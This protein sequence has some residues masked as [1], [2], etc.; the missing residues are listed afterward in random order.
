MTDTHADPVTRPS[1]DQPAGEGRG[2]RKAREKRST[3]DHSRPAVLRA[4]AWRDMLRYLRPHRGAILV[5]GGLTLLGGLSGLVQP[6]MAKSVV[7]GLQNESS[8]T[9]TLLLLSAFVLISAALGALGTFLLMRVSETVVLN[10]RREVIRKVL[11]LRVSETDK[12]PPGD[13]MSRATADTTLMRSAVTT[14]I[15]ETVNG[16]VMLTTIVVLMGFMDVV[17][18]LTTLGVLLLGGVVIGVGLPQLENASRRVQEGV[19]ELSTALERVLGTFRTIKAS[20]A[21]HREAEIAERGARRAWQSSLKVARLESFIGAFITVMIQISFLAVLGV[22][23]ARVASGAMSLGSLI[24][25]LLYLFYLV[26]PLGALVTAMMRFN[27]VAAALGRVHE[28]LRLKTEP[29]SPPAPPAADR[30]A[31]PA[32]VAFRDVVFRY[33]GNDTVVHHDISFDIPRGGMTAFVGPSG[34]GKSTVFALIER[35][36]EAERG[37]VLLDGKDVTEWPLG[38][39]RASIGYVEQDAPVLAGTLRDNLCIG[40]PD[41][42]DAAILEAVGQARLEEVVARLPQGLDTEVGHRGNKLSGGERQRVAVAR[43]L[44]RKPRLLLLDEV[45]SQL[46]A[47][48]ENALREVIAEVSG[49][50]TVVVVAHRLSTVS[51]ADRIVVMDAGRIRAIGSH[52]Q[53]LSEDALYRELAATQLLLPTTGLDPSAVRPAGGVGRTV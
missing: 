2:K 31:E 13:L 27:V 11:W 8:V 17:L 10:S 42:D 12:F 25:F 44:L 36:Y 41:A 39:L 24:A 15:V 45:T 20:G 34:A 23:G 51:M 16:A 9:R 46:D 49:R 21:E 7:E 50:T 4:D 37:Q 48:N 3:A 52:E 22:G 53:L 32:S 35:F 5:G 6:I 38:D 28:M 1:D 40:V 26:P 29:E 14:T 19:A 43:A 30:T 47:R 33:P 18:L